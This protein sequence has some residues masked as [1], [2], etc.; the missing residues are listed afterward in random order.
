MWLQKR[1]NIPLYRTSRS[2]KG[3]V[4]TP[5]LENIGPGG[6]VTVVSFSYICKKIVGHEEIANRNTV[7]REDS[8]GKLSVR[9]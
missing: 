6:S 8:K 4:Q 9:G 3:D 5:G 1:G 7:V 2:S